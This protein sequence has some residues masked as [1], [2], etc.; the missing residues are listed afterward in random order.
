MCV[1][2]EQSLEECKDF[3]PQPDTEGNDMM[4]TKWIGMNDENKSAE[5]EK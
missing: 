2:L 3:F 5:Q 1:T 4:R